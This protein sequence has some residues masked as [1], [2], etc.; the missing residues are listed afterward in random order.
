LIDR[1]RNAAYNIGEVRGWLLKMTQSAGAVRALSACF[2]AAY[3]GLAGTSLARQTVP[4][5]PASTRAEEDT[6]R[7]ATLSFLAV[8]HDGHPVV[9]LQAAQLSLRINHQP[10][11]ILSLTSTN[12]DPRT[13]G[14]FFDISASSRFDKAIAKEAQ[15]TANFLGSIWHAGD[16]GFVVVFNAQPYPLEDA[17]PN[18][19]RIQAA[20]LG[21]PREFPGGGT[22]LYDALCSIRLGPQTRGREKVFVVAS[23]FEDNESHISQEKTIRTMQEEGVRIVV[24]QRVSDEVEHP[25][26]ALRAAENAKEVA[27][28]TGGD[29]FVV[30]NQ[31]DLDAAFQRLA[32][33]F[34]GSYRL[35][36][37]PLPS[38]GKSE[39]QE[40]ETT[41]RD[42]DLLY[43]RN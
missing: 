16:T 21:V 43:P 23:D 10:R 14:V 22:A 17:G 7:N 9:G 24:L 35:T 32:A 11:R 33:E 38:E 18:L 20:L 8:G 19:L 27:E 3:L 13:I 4:S 39:K 15:G 40:L 1:V 30:K 12:D 29:F 37:E 5:A 28:K 36:Y 41:R 31:T 34:Q 26:T 2:L 25:K 6:G 42:V